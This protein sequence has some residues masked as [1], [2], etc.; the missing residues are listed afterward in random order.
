MSGTC[1]E[2]WHM[3]QR[4]TNQDHFSVT[5]RGASAAIRFVVGSPGG[6]IGAG[7][8]LFVAGVR[9]GIRT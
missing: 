5:E 1:E 4:D 6:H 9:G 2:G 8:L 3:S 7:G